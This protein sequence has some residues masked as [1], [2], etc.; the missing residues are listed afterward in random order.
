VRAVV[1]RSTHVLVALARQQFVSILEAV[2]VTDPH[3]TP[4]ELEPQS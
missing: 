2:P 1:T 4:T 3:A